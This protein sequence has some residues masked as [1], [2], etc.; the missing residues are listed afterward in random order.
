MMHAGLLL[1][2]PVDD[3]QAAISAVFPR[4]R[5]WKDDAGWHARRKGRFRDD[6]IVPDA[7]AYAVH[8]DDPLMLVL[9]LHHQDQLAPPDGWDD[10][11]NAVDLFHEQTAREIEAEFPG[12][13]VTYGP[14]GWA[15]A[16]DGHETV[17]AQS[18]QGLRALLP[19]AG[20]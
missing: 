10:K 7:P 5:V 1:D 3:V 14:Y 16:R 19:Y 2:F 17:R 15:A 13:K 9:Q 6:R 8:S 18:A 20:D 11:P 4:W 12:R